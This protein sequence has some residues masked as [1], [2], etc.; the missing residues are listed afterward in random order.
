MKNQDLG[1]FPPNSS[2]FTDPMEVEIVNVDSTL[3]RIGYK[4]VHLTLSLIIT[5]S[6]LIS[7]FCSTHQNI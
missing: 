4:I 6:L 1:F 3:K 2:F 5:C 7:L